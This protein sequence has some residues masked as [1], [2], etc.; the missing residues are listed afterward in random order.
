MQMKRKKSHAAWTAMLA[1]AA[2]LFFLPLSVLFSMA[3]LETFS[4]E[5]LAPKMSS[6][7]WIEKYGQPFGSIVKPLAEV[8]RT[9]AGG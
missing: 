2:L 1:V 3:Y 7:E 8:V 5:L 6:F 4:G 9:I